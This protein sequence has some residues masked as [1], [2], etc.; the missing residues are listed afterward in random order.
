MI[1]EAQPAPVLRLRARNTRPRPHPRPSR[2]R[3]RGPLGIG[4]RLA[5]GAGGPGRRVRRSRFTG[6]HQRQI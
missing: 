2:P 1:E 4:Q 3:R 6:A 5:G